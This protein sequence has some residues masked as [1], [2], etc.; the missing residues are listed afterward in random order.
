MLAYI[1]FRGPFVKTYEHDPC[2]ASLAQFSQASAGFARSSNAVA[3][4][5][6]SYVVN[7]LTGRNVVPASHE[8]VMRKAR[9]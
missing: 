4:T 9:T 3:S 6:Q 8:Y 5:G 2:A 7:R 1:H